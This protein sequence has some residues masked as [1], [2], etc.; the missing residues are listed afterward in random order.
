MDGYEHSR[1]DC[2]SVVDGV[3]QTDVDVV[4]SAD[5]AHRGEAGVDRLARKSRGQDGLLRRLPHQSL[6]VLKVVVVAI[7]LGEM[8]VRI[9]QAGEE[10]G[11][12]EVDYLRVRGDVDVGAGRDDVVS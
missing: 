9:D 2:P 12:P 5:V 1:A 3:A 6:K 4:V 7:L 8:Y 11:I 10:C